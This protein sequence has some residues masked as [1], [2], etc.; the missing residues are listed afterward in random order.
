MI[1]N[2]GVKNALFFLNAD[3]EK[4]IIVLIKRKYQSFTKL[5]F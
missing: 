5:F 4:K 1:C 2:V 3:A